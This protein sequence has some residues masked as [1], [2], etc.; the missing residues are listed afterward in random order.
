MFFSSS[1]SVMKPRNI[2]LF[3]RKTTF[4]K[5][6][7]KRKREK[8]RKRKREKERERRERKREVSVDHQVP[9]LERSPSYFSLS[10]ISVVLPL[11]LSHPSILL[12]LFPSFSLIHPSF[13][14]LWKA[15]HMPFQ[16]VLVS[17]S[18]YQGCRCYSLSL[19]LFQFLGRRKLVTHWK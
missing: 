19:S 10:L 9:P 13:F 2:R 7:R 14:L 17:R 4:R 18:R 11:S 16:T 15:S 8:G 5:K 3:N 12:S 1:F 6:E